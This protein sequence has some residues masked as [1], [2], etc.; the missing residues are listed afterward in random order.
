MKNELQAEASDDSKQAVEAM[1][2]QRREKCTRTAVAVGVL[3]MGVF[4]IV[5]GTM[6]AV[7]DLVVNLIDVKK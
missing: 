5:T 2:A 6:A 3:V 4:V 1:S 7:Q